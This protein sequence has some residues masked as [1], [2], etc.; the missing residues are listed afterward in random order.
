MSPNTAR[1]V[2]KIVALILVA[3]LVITSF[4][5][6]F[7]L[8]TGRGA[9]YG[10]TATESAELDRQLSELKDLLLDVEENY[11]DDV[12]FRTLVEGA[13]RGVLEALDDPYSVYFPTSAEADQFVES[14]SGE[15]SG[16]GVSVEDFGG[17]VRIVAPLA[18]TPAEAAGIKAGDIITRVD[19]ASVAGLSLDQVVLL[20]KGEAGTKV[21]V[22]VERNGTP[23]TF[24][25][26][27][28]VIRSASVTFELKEA[29]LGYI[30]IAQF[31]K[32]THLEFK[33]AK[34]QLIAQG[35]RGLVI[36]VRNN[37]GGFTS[38]ASDIASQMMPAGPITHFARR[39]AIVE[40]VTADGQGDLGL[41]LVL[42]V[43]EGTASAAEIL[44]GAWQDSG[45]AVLVGANTFGKGV[46]QQ[47]AELP[48]G[49]GIK[50][51]TFYFLTPDQRPID[52][53][54]LAPDYTVPA[55][56]LG[57]VPGTG[58]DE[59][60]TGAPGTGTDGTATGAWLAAYR[61]F[62]P[63]AEKEKPKAGD[64]GLNVYGAQQR[65]GLLGYRVTVTGTMDP[66]TVEAVR[67]FQREKGL[68]VYGV[69]D[70][71]TMD[72]LDRAAAAL[73]TGA[74]DGRDLQL[75]KALE[76]LRPQV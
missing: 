63:M 22:T 28:A 35:A 61:S 58:T 44:A 9:V 7:F 70:Y 76:L 31:D 41:P 20:L 39:G 57:G 8:G 1:T 5:F 46:A 50:L 36:D 2:A 6:V 23:L 42:L 49:G 40:T 74:S 51:S 65:L 26:V 38:V 11:K 43:N 71:S 67:A 19:G 69:L 54:G 15:F 30:R 59:T 14:V 47:V 4:S 29:G 52:K 24:S 10:A 17:V 55:G 60:A 62:A 37:P 72:R 34:L 53:V 13:F 33:N 25:L 18:G 16:I 56:A 45:A 32:D 73:A 64:T 3:A 12:E 27:R 21:S 66:S 68:Y 48:G 75:E